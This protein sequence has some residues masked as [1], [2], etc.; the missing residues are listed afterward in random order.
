MWPER[1]GT[2][3]RIASCVP[4]MTACRLISSWREML[5]GALLQ[6]RRHRHDPGVVDEHVERPELLLHLVEE[7]GEAGVVGHVERQPERAGA[8]L[9]GDRFRRLTVEVADRYPGSL[10]RQRQGGGAADAAAAT[11]DGNDFSGERARFLSHL[12]NLAD[13]TDRLRSLATSALREAGSAAA[14]GSVS[15]LVA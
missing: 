10:T 14:A 12:D 1:R 9:G 5:S 8:E 3:R 11:G 7:G 15:L 4:W 13:A 2:M 6:Q